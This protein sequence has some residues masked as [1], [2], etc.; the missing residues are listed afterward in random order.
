L[1]LF[2]KRRNRGPGDLIGYLW[3]FFQYDFPVIK[4]LEEPLKNAA[5]IEEFLSS[6]SL[7]DAHFSALKNYFGSENFSRASYDA[8][9][10]QLRLI[11][12]S[13]DG[14]GERLWRKNSQDFS[15]DIEIKRSVARNINPL[16]WTEFFNQWKSRL[17]NEFKDTYDA[18]NLPFHEIQSVLKKSQAET[19]DFERELTLSNLDPLE[20][21]RRRRFFYRQRRNDPDLA[22]VAALLVYHRIEYNTRSTSLLNADEGDFILNLVRNWF[23]YPRTIAHKSLAHLAGPVLTSMRDRIPTLRS[24]IEN[25]N[26]F[27]ERLHRNKLSV[28]YPSNSLK[29]GRYYF[30]S[31]PRNFHGIWYGEPNGDC[32]ATLDKSGSPL[33][34]RWGLMAVEGAQSIHIRSE[35]KYFGSLMIIPISFEGQTYGLIEFWSQIFLLKGVLQETEFGEVVSILNLVFEHLKQ[36]KP[37]SWAGYCICPWL[38]FDNWSV[39][40]YIVSDESFSPS[41]NIAMSDSVEINDEVA[42]AVAG[43]SERN[44]KAKPFAPGLVHSA[45]GKTH[46]NPVIF[47]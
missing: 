35:Q 25:R 24:L 5:S 45:A 18:Q 1:T 22:R 20:Q 9:L 26:V 10:M 30:E 34:A 43:F 32:L 21:K 23:Q 11:N 2:P 28:Y 7:I 17:R 37:E 13:V 15:F 29:A 8:I 41:G 3:V 40:R 42:N 14:L 47:L 16:G 38:S 46:S 31:L 27:P 4:Q 36:R 6:S 19:D 33:A 44:L 12:R 39:M